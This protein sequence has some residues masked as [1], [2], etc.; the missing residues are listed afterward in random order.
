MVASE[1]A[2][3]LGASCAPIGAKLPIMLGVGEKS[4]AIML[5]VLYL[6]YPARLGAEVL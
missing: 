1:V 3:R 5:H 2:T 6:C 4:S